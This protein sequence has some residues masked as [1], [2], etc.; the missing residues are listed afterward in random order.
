MRGFCLGE[1]SEFHISAHRR[2]SLNPQCG[3]VKELI[4]THG[5]VEG[6]G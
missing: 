3:D 4:I 5:H 6:L 2:H 1:A